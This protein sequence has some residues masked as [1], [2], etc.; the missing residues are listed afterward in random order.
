MKGLIRKAYN[1]RLKALLIRW[2]TPPGLT[3]EDGIRYWQGRILF[4]L[5]LAG[6]V[7]GFFVYF[8]S[9][10]LCI[11][12]ELWSVGIADTIIYALIIIL[13]FRRSIPFAVRAVTFVLIAYILGIVL[14][15]TVGPFGAGSV[16]LFAFPV[17]AGLFM[18][19]RASLIA[20]GVNAGTI[21]IIGILISLGYLKWDYSTINAAEKWAVIGLNFTF[22]N[23]VVAVSVAVI[24]RGLQT[25]L[26]QEKSMLVS[27]EKEHCQL[28]E[29]NRQLKREMLERNRAEDALQESEAKYRRLYEESRRV[30]EVYRSLLHTSADAIVTY[31]MEGKVSYVNPSFKRI[32]GWTP[33]EVEGKRLPLVPESEKKASMA[34]IKRIVEEG[35]GIQSF[36]TKRYLKDGSLIDVSISGS[37]Y[38]DH[39]GNPAGI[40]VVLRDTSKRKKLEA[41]LQQ[42]GRM[43]SLGTLAGGIAHD[44]NNLLMGIQGRTSLMRID[45]DSS[46]PDFEH[47]KGIED[48][49]NSAADLTKQLLGFARGGKYEV[50]PTDIN[51]LIKKSSTMFG[52]TK[53]EI[54][55]HPKYQEDIRTVEVDQGQID[56]VLMNLYVNAWQAMPWGGDLYLA[57]ENVTIDEN[58]VKPFYVGP[59]KYVKISVTDT[60]VGMDKATQER[61]FEPFFTTKE[62]GRGTGLGLASVYGIIKN[63]GG[64]INVYSEKGEGATFNIYLPAS[65]SGVSGRMKEISEDVRHGSE[66]VL[67]VDDEEMIIEVGEQLIEGLGYRVLTARSGKEAIE[68]YREN[69]DQIDMVILD[70]IMPDMG[71]GEAYDRLKEIDPDVKVLLSSGYSINAQSAEIVN[72]GCN[73]FIQKPFNMKQ[74]SRKFRGVLDNK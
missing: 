58:Y 69:K 23:S 22:L 4:T 5:L 38:N 29:S 2:T 48:Y 55:I 10:A 73:G 54:R 30:G 41:R 11:K 37:R 36:E 74:L 27:L 39:E 17:I 16:W 15:L 49:V 47:L 9:V 57:T 66:T 40:L 12:E 35:A 6:V 34:G 32:F 19:L 44:F 72:R 71:G 18:G 28:D 33:E 70:M 20:L 59:G 1:S 25:L 60:G 42:T 64:F 45:K 51:D 14:L 7:L 21:I 31:D 67:F 43:E 65:E 3:R 24:L 63:H 50:R 61:I 26:E 46:H 56:Q 8:P 62:M 13:F 68:I 52:R 53:K